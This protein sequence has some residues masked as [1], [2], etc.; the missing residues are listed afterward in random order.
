MCFLRTQSVGPYNNFFLLTVKSKFRIVVALLTAE[1]K[2]LT[3]TEY[4]HVYDLQRIQFHMPNSNSVLLIVMK[5]NGKEKFRTAAAL[6]LYITS[7]PYITSTNVPHL[8]NIINI[9]LHKFKGS[10]TCDWCRSHLKRP[11]VPHVIFAFNELY[12]TALQ[13]INNVSR[14]EMDNTYWEDNMVTP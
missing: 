14:F 10:S 2:H 7:S 1:Q 12:S 9:G 11:C 13:Q 6:L 5:P 8:F 4:M 3:H